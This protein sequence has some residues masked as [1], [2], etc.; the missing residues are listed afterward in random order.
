MLVVLTHAR[1]VFLDTPTW[2]L[3]NEL[4][5]AGASG[6]DLFFIVSGFIMAYTTRHSDGSFSDAL[7]FLIKRVARIWPVYAVATLFW[8]FVAFEGVGFFRQA[9]SWRTLAL[10]LSFQP[11]NLEAPLFFGMALP[12]GWTLNFEIYFYAIFALSLVTGRLRGLFLTTWILATVIALPWFKRGLSMDVMT[13]FHFS[14]AY[15]NLVT[16][17]IVLEFLAGAMIGW[18]YTQGW[19]RL[20]SRA[21]CMHLMLFSA[22]L[23]IWYT[24]SGVGG[25]HGPTRW[26]WAA[27]LVVLAMALASKTVDITPPAWLVWLG[28]ISYSLYLTH[29]TSQLLVGW[30]VAFMGG[31]KQTWTYIMLSTAVAISIAAVAHHYL[32]EKL[33][34]AV[35]RALLRA[36]RRYLKPPEGSG[37]VQPAHFDAA[38]AAAPVRER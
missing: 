13:N 16:S 31:S 26:G 6:V 19:F 36:F 32:E 8:L 4:L 24:Y 25:F 34:F 20:R 5:F 37:H 15:L 12:L 28:T 7:E 38:V 9:G 18:C 21:L 29:T 17:P 2:P 14:L 11:V 1:Y 10:S 23:F 35:R 33:S 3:A 27:A 30:G 22:S